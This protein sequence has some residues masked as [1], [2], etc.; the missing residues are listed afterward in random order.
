V[1]FFTAAGE[2]P[3]CGHGTVAAVAV[4]A[5]ADGATFR[6]RLRIGGRLV[7]AAGVVGPGGVVEAWF[8]GAVVALRP[9]V[10]EEVAGVLEALALDPAALDG[11]PVVADPG[12][13][14]LLLP[15]AGREVL[16][17]LR[18]DHDRLA[19][20]TG[21]A[22]LLGCFAYAPPS[23]AAATDPGAPA[24]TAARMFAPAIG[25]PEDV[26]NA[27]SAGCLA[28]HLLATGRAADVIVDQGD[29]LGSPSSVHAS[30]RR[31]PDGLAMTLTGTARLTP[32]GG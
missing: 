22:G 32:T 8:D 28:A 13:P 17:A 6:G 27:N 3:S 9:A 19:A 23:P 1:R 29:A 16:D 11:A 18:P 7:A 14:R 31:T 21:R 26:C 15:V 4:L 10:P 30:A 12:R 24:R 25:V 5:A 2:L 20:A